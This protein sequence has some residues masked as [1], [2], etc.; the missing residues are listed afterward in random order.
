MVCGGFTCSKNALAALNVLYIV[1]IASKNEGE[2][3]RHT[4]PSI[5]YLFYFIY[6]FLVAAQ[7]ATW[8]GFLLSIVPL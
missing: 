2:V 5:A 8:L 7:A 4:F 3:S 6:L 1:S